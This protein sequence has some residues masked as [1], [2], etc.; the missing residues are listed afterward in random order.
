MI[1]SYINRF[2]LSIIAQEKLLEMIQK[3]LPLPNNLPK[4]LN[5]LKK[6]TSDQNDEISQ[7]YFCDLC[8]SELGFGKLCSNEN[9]T[10]KDSVSKYLNS[11][12]YMSIKPRLTRLVKNHIDEIENLKTNNIKYRD[13]IHSD[14]F[15]NISKDNQ[16][17]LMVYTDGIAISKSNSQNFWP[18]LIGLC[19]LPINLRVSIKNKIVYGVW[20]GKNKPTSDILFST[21]IEELNSINQTGIVFQKRSI[22]YNFHIQIYGILCD[23]PAKAIILNM[24]Q[25]NGYFGC[26]YCLNPGKFIF[27]FLI[28]FIYFKNKSFF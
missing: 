23:T 12:T 18:V 24:N 8:L 10:K 17:N 11:F 19:D 28:K 27:S 25:F 13:L 21:L 5:K 14:H 22:T 2:D 4:T 16:L 9:C 26:A 1:V 3:F 15:K 6:I 7:K 20:F